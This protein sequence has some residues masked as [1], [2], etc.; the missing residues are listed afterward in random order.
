[1]YKD[2]P[3]HSE[4]DAMSYAA[5]PPPSYSSAISVSDQ[6]RALQGSPRSEVGFG[7]EQQYGGFSE[8]EQLRREQELCSYRT[9]G[10]PSGSSSSFP[11]SSGFTNSAPP[12]AKT[13]L[14]TFGSPFATSPDWS[15][16]AHDAYLTQ[17][18]KLD[19]ELRLKMRF[20][21]PSAEQRANAPPPSWNRS[22]ASTHP[23]ASAHFESV[24][25]RS[26]N[27][28]SAAHKQI[29][30][31]GFQN[32]YPGRLM[33]SRD[34]S[35]ADWARFNEDMVVAGRLTGA[36]SIVSNVAPIT[37]HLG[38][39]GFF[40][41]RAIEKGMKKRKDPLICA[42][43]EL[44]QQNF[45]TSRKLDV[46]IL[47]NG[48]RLTARSP[49]APVPVSAAQIQRSDTIASSSSSSSSS[50]SDSSENERQYIHQKSEGRILSKRERKALKKEMK[51][52]RKQL[53][54]EH[55]HERKMRRLERK[56]KR[57]QRG[58]PDLVTGARQGY[59]LVIA[60]LPAEGGAVP[61][62]AASFML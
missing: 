60:P 57:R 49:N 37:M 45:F 53:K 16:S 30:A 50:S 31:D 13:A 46:Y 8:K 3:A 48:Q 34:V 23:S 10:A 56:N 58:Y 18:P 44:W 22:F 4:A 61:V 51:A 19:I 42:T 38:A 32:S 7:K 11:S 26:A 27:T 39:T 6:A 21:G 54:A 5:M 40:V 43:V 35:S 15:P 9:T 2:A 25:I 33:V 59:F 1:M 24:Y 36:Q 28:K 12:D 47:H 55:K 52:E 17:L 41:T 14:A 20:S 62:E 29:L